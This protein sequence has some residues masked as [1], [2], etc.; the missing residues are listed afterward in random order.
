M[1]SFLR[2]IFTLAKLLSNRWSLIPS[3]LLLS[4]ESRI[5]SI[6]IFCVFIS[7]ISTNSY[8][9]N[10]QWA[11]SDGRCPTSSATATAQCMQQNYR[12]TQTFTGISD[13][14]CTAVGSCNALAHYTQFY[15]GFLHYYED[16]LI[17]SGACPVGAY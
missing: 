13:L 14:S 16:G 6:F 4:Q 1:K 9:T 10:F 7:L 8:A 3:V 2:S 5:P 12:S 11:N 15:D 17:A